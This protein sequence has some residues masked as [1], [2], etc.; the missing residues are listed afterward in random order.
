MS[1]ISYIFTFSLPGISHRPDQW[2]HIFSYLDALVSFRSVFPFQHHRPVAIMFLFITGHE[3]FGSYLYES[4]IF[5]N[6]ICNRQN[7]S[8][9]KELKVGSRAEKRQ[10][11]R[12]RKKNLS[13]KNLNDKD[14][15]MINTTC[16][17]NVCKGKEEVRILHVTRQRSFTWME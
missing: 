7:R 17:R 15:L 5:D 14:F 16:N 4:F 9:S 3:G 1:L 11:T 12:Q 2:T 13:P 10:T 6:F 8:T